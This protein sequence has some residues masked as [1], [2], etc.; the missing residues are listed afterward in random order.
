MSSHTHVGIWRLANKHR[1]LYAETQSGVVQNIFEEAFGDV[2]PGYLQFL[3]KPLDELVHFI[4]R[5]SK[6]DVMLMRIIGG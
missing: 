3:Q 2:P 1:V 4:N 6:V 5:E